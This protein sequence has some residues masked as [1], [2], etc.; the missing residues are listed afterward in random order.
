[1]GRKKEVDY[2]EMLKGQVAFAKE[3]SEKLKSCIEDYPNLKLSE[4]IQEMHTIEHNGDQAK[5]QLEDHLMREFLPP[6]DREDIVLLASMIDDV[7]DHIEDVLLRLYIFNVHR[8]RPEIHEFVDLISKCTAALVEGIAEFRD[9]RKSRVL[10][11]KIIEVN[12]LEE[13]GDKL[14]ERAIRNLYTDGSDA[15]EKLTWT[16][17]FD[18]LEKCCD[19][20]EHT[21]DVLSRVIMSNT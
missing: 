13:Q 18:H 9:F 16:E 3:A 12:T 21:V 1:M 10:G 11:E 17:I 4:S 14:Y 15:V 7:T 5:H 20:C 19:A 6:I 2:F 8:L